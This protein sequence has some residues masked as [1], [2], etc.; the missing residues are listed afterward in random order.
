MSWMILSILGAFFQA[1]GAAIKKKALQVPGMNNSIGFISFTVAGLIFGALYFFQ[2][3]TLWHDNLTMRFWEGMFWYAGLNI[4]AV[5]F[6]Y[7]ALDIS[8]FSYLMPFMTL[9]SLSVIIPPYFI[10]GEIPSMVSFF[11][12]ALV[13]IGALAINYEPQKSV[14]LT[15]SEKKK[16]N[17]RRGLMYFIAT[18]ICFTI[19]PTAAKIA[20]LESSVLFASFLVHIL[21]GSG[22][23]VMIVVFK[24]M[25]KLKEVFGKA[26][27]RILLGG[28]ILAGIVIVAENGVINAALGM[29]KVAYVMAI[30]RLM[31]VFAFL[32]SIFYFKEKYNL[33]KKFLATILMVAGAAMMGIFK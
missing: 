9:T 2:T 28:I 8:E 11:G 32:I 10:L 17:N 27:R 33:R 29:E 19:T 1:T 30:K 7:R 31:P 22:F 15:Q 23:L 4:V 6:L 5:W 12:I 13:V 16:K 20:V 18:A 21:I 26:S 25:G 24:E 14:D 3:G